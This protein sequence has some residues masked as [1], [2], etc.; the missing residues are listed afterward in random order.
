MQTWLSF[1]CVFGL[2]VCQLDSGLPPEI[3]I[4]ALK[5]H[6]VTG[7]FAGQLV[8][9]AKSRGN[10][11]TLYFFLPSHKW[12][13]PTAR[14]LRELDNEIANRID[15]AHICAIWLTTDITESKECLPRAQMSLKLEHTSLTVFDGN[16]YGPGEW[17]INTEKDVT[18]VLASGGKS[19]QSHSYVSA[20]ETLAQSVLDE[21]EKAVNKL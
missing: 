8:D 9:Y 15:D 18:I 11:P 2:V 21:F 6:S 12:S 10:K 13:R 1:A 4:P 5:V 16:E 17:G 19:I 3:S 14:F 20:N 7:E